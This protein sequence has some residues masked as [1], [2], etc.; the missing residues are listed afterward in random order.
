MNSFKDSANPIL[1]WADHFHLQPIELNT[2]NIQIGKDSLKKSK[3]L[4]VKAKATHSVK[5][6]GNKLIYLPFV[7]RDAVQSMVKPYGKPILAAHDEEKDNIGRIVSATYVPTPSPLVSDSIYKYIDSVNSASDAIPVLKQIYD[8]LTDP[9]FEGFGYIDVTYRI[10]D[11]SAIE[12]IL[13]NRYLTV[14]V[15]FSFDKSLTYNSVNGLRIQDEDNET[16]PGETEDGYTVFGVISGMKVNELS[17]VNVPADDLAM[18]YEHQMEDSVQ[19]EFLTSDLYIESTIKNGKSK[20]NKI[21]KT[22]TYAQDSMNY[23]GG[24]MRLSKFAELLKD[25]TLAYDAM[26]KYLEAD[27]VI[28]SEDLAK[29]EDRYFAG[30]NK[31]FPITNQEHKDAALKVLAEFEDKKH[32]AY[33][34]LVEAITNYEI[35]TPSVS[36]EP[37]PESTETTM[38][39][40]QIM[41]LVVTKLGDSETRKDIFGKLSNDN[42]KSIFDYLYP[43]AIESKWIEIASVNN[44][45]LQARIAELETEKAQTDAIVDIFKARTTNLQKTVDKYKAELEV[46]NG[47]IKGIMIDQILNIKEDLGINI[48]NKE[49]AKTGLLSR[50]VDSLN[51]SIKDLKDQLAIFKKKAPSTTEVLDDPTKSTGTDSQKEDYAKRL[52]AIEDEYY[53]LKS[54]TALSTANEWRRIMISNL[55]NEF[56][57]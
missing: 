11:E 41:D 36:A 21:N 10:T 1:L 20:L 39:D 25:N 22:H 3:G 48:A 55:N 35:S 6:T 51:D 30:P 53:K 31:T 12:K 44:D 46:S 15:G 38:T 32:K 5:P 49:E 57:K 4:V 23:N 17:Y 26:K 34:A 2:S 7:L 16:V 45:A 54:K 18:S 19:S 56:S 13:D 40:A 52:E 9:D 29:L 50:S 28:L 43:I 33:D 27:K 47:Q 42:L 37:T 14:S 24:S 8:V